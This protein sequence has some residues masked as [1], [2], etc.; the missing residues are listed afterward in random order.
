[1]N[2]GTHQPRN[3]KFGGAEHNVIEVSLLGKRAPPGQQSEPQ[4]VW[5]WPEATGQT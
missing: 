4:E 2:Q 3:V 1:M 5:L